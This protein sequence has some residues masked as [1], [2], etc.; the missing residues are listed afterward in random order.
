[1][2]DF[3]P[4]DPKKKEEYA[5]YLQCAGER[6]CEYCFVNL[7]LW[8]RQKAAFLYDHLAF[9]SQFNRKSVYMFPVGTGDK[10]AV[11]DAI[12]ADAGERGIP[13][14]LTGLTAADCTLLE[15]LYPGKFRY[16]FDRDA[17]DYIYDIHDLADLKGRKFQR[18]RNHLNRFREA[19]P[20][21]TVEPITA[22]N[23]TQVQQL[24]AQWY[25]LRQAQDPHAD[26][27]MEQAAIS[28]ALQCSEVLGLEGLLLRV[29]GKPTAMSMGSWL[30]ADTFDIHFEKALD[31]ADGAYAAINN[32]FAKYL[33]EKY[34][35][36]RWLNRED[37]MGLEGL[38]KAKLSY[39]P[40]RMVEKYWAHLL[41][42]GYDY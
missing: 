25:A 42:D 41:E 2:I 29:K 30:N 39:N 22:E 3:Q 37:D 34:P 20:D 15:Q 24:V 13:C 12:M 6:G 5:Q 9:F 14:R 38:R 32:G 4:L 27:H 18:K 11:L 10:K 35:Q 26:Y 16:H 8:G 40:A 1:M 21:H 36:L 7:Y 28:K 31:I 17:F 23:L 19:N 33:R